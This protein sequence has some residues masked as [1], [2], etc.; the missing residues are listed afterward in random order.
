MVARIRKPTRRAQHV[1]RTRQ[2]Y[3]ESKK[4]NNQPVKRKI[5]LKPTLNP[6]RYNAIRLH[7]VMSHQSAKLWCE[8]NG[9]IKAFANA[10]AGFRRKLKAYNLFISAHRIPIVVLKKFVKYFLPGK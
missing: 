7:K 6:F 5:N 1:T 9:D 2:Q 4:V 10:M 8:T 3:S